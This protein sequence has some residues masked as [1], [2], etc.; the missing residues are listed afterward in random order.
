MAPVMNTRIHSGRMLFIILVIQV[1]WC[2]LSRADENFVQ[3]DPENHQNTNQISVQ[4]D[5]E[6]TTQ[7]PVQDDPENEDNKPS[8]SIQP[9]D[10][11]VCDRIKD[12][13]NIAASLLENLPTVQ[14]PKGESGPVGPT[15]MCSNTV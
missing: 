1:Q 7:I 9:P 3:D 5:P 15:G 4:N 6:N 11:Q 2:R 12:G 14:G 10:I 8:C 13:V